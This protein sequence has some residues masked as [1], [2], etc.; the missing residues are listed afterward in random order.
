MKSDLVPDPSTLPPAQPEA[1]RS[2]HTTTFPELLNQLG[3][4]LLISTY[5]AG[6][7]IVVRDQDGE[8]NTHFRGFAMPMGMAVHG[9]RL[10]LG[11]KLQVWDFRN[12]PEAGRTL[13]PAGKHDAVFVP[14]AT[15][16]T[17]DIRIHEIAWGADD[18]WIV[19][20]RFS[21]LC[22]LDRDNS[23]VPRWRPPF[24]TALSSDDRCH[25]NGLALVD[26]TPGY[27][28][29]LGQT[30]TPGGWRANKASGGCLLAVPS[31]AVIAHGL[32][33]PHSP[34][35]Y[36]GKLWVLESGDGGIAVVDQQTGKRETVAQLPGFTRGLDFC[37][38]YAFV[39]L[40]QVRETAIFSGLPI[41][42]LKERICGVW[43]VDVR[44]GQTVA[45]LQFEDAVQEIFAVQVLPGIR[46]PE[47]ASE[48]E[49]LLANSFVLPE[50]A[51]KDVAPP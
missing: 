33:M 24:V 36:G 46:Y 20:T 32:S 10:A 42:V 17:G 4:S 18:L 37:G 22:T 29:C 34:R 23:F 15:H 31:G 41:T 51:M 30:D 28:T 50:E 44:S 6:K 43:V 40:S 26:G 49:D 16:F 5:Q 13:E 25:L 7:L 1:L 8:L 35:W 12:Q 21:C 3:I 47:I 2:V 48:D 38:P 14:R 9:D 27:F 11:T 19:N 45:F 39:G